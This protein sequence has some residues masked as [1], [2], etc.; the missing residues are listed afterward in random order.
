MMTGKKFRLRLMNRCAADN[1]VS[2]SDTK[3]YL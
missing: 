1:D 3:N 2:I